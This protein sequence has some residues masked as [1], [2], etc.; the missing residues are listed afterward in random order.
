MHVAI[1]HRPSDPLSLQVYE[2]SMCRELS[3]LGVEMTL[4]EENRTPP[5]SCDILWDPGDLPP[6]NWSTLNVR[7]MGR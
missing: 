2:Q 1:I 3:A 5:D 6:E 7:C 4:I